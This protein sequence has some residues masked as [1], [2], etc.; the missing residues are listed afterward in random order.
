MWEQPRRTAKMVKG[1]EGSVWGVAEDPWLVQPR[2]EELRRGL[3]AAAAP[4]REWRAALSSALCDSNRAWGNGMELCQ[5]EDWGVK[6]LECDSHG[7]GCPGQCA[8][9]EL[10]EFKECQDNVLRDRVWILGG[11]V[12]SQMLDSLTHTSPFQHEIFY[13]SQSQR[14][15]VLE[16]D[17]KRSLS[18]TRELNQVLYNRSHR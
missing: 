2:A 13:K 11:P 9:P 7:T 5:G 18:P 14:I 8:Q 6:R 15:T 16:R 1:L 10:A 17:L 3:M 4:H 12:Y